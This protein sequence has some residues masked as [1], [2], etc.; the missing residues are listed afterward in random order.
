METKT[1][2]E[3]FWSGEFGDSYIERNEN[4]RLLTSNINF[5]IKSLQR[6]KN[7]K[8]CIEFGSNVG[9][10]IKS[11]K[12]IYPDLEFHA[13]EINK[14]AAKFLEEIISPENIFQESILDFESKQKWNLS[15]VKGVLI[16]INPEK[17]E[18]AYK[19]I[20][21]ASDKY[22]LICEYY[23]RKPESLIYRGHSNKLFKRDFAGEILD[24]FPSL[25]LIDYGFVYH[26]D[27]NFPQDDISWFLIEKNN[28]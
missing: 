7:L 15:L 28:K 6:T 25:S 1:D 14:K 16:H 3:F 23:S 24:L 18:E 21:N 11:L 17:L 19:R 22:I 10:N 12:I 2:Q 20:V 13:V 5:F 26:K 27:P 4:K 8:T 9:M